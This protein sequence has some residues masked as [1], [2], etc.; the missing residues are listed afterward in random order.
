[1]K[2]DTKDKHGASTIFGAEL[3]DR[4]T[5]STKKT[6]KGNK[7]NISINEQ[8]FKNSDDE[9]LPKGELCMRPL[10]GQY[11]SSDAKFVDDYRYD[12]DLMDDVNNHD[13]NDDKDL[14]IFDYGNL[15][16]EEEEEE[17]EAEEMTVRTFYS[18]HEEETQK[19]HESFDSLYIDCNTQF[20]QPDIGI[21]SGEV[22]AS[23]I[24][25]LKVMDGTAGDNEGIKKKFRLI[26]R[27]CEERGQAERLTNSG[28]SKAPVLA[29]SLSSLP[30]SSSSQPIQPPVLTLNS[31]ARAQAQA[32]AKKDQKGRR[33]INRIHKLRILSSLKI[34]QT[35]RAAYEAARCTVKDGGN[36]ADDDEYDDWSRF[37][38]L[39]CAG[40]NHTEMEVEL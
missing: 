14:D 6:F 31:Q 40:N 30:S 15:E 27:S 7:R 32:A 21:Q 5:N 2:I 18:E 8:A 28:A 37:G 12:R 39:V 36:Y 10:F 35:R 34:S 24:P 17:E 23:H 26:E 1:M 25:N 29:P 16:E 3:R 22:E 38:G 19:E 13:G 20:T 9:R 33:K 4:R 11:C